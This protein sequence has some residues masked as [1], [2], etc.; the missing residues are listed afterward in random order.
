MSVSAPTPLPFQRTLLTEAEAAAY[1]GFVADTLRVWR[2]K[3]RRARKL[4]GPKWIELG[5]QGRAR[6]IRYRIEDLN[7]YTTRGVITLE[8]PKRVG[9]PR[10]AAPTAA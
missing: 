8:P 5:G 2:S 6:A 4:I 9:R 3:S 7:D 10:K 1:L